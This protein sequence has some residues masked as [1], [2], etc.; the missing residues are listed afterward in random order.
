MLTLLCTFSEGVPGLR[1]VRGN[2]TEAPWVQ[3]T[4]SQ[5]LELLPVHKGLKAFFSSRQ[6]WAY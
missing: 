5:A 2:R 6:P 4:E 1:K 3:R